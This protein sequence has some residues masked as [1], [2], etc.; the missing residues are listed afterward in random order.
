MAKGQI[1]LHAYCTEC[2]KWRLADWTTDRPYQWNCP[3]CGKC[4]VYEQEEKQ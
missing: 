3:T 4:I 2:Q 1:W